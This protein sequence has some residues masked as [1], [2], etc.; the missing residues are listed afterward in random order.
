MSTRTLSLGR[1]EAERL[2]PWYYG[3]SRAERSQLPWAL[4]SHP[5]CSPSPGADSWVCL[6]HL[7]VG[8]GRELRGGLRWGGSQGCPVL[9]TLQGERLHS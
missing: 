1:V 7:E 4:A 8:S 9:G 6:C 2:Q 3:I 5:R